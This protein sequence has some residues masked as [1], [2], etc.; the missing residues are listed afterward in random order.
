MR[1][2]SFWRW[3]LTF[4]VKSTAIVHGEPL[5]SYVVGDTVAGTFDS[6][7]DRRIG[8]FGR[9]E[10]AVDRVSLLDP[11]ASAVAGNRVRVGGEDY[12]IVG[13]DDTETVW[14][15]ALKRVVHGA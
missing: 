9:L 3:R 12:D 2:A 8:R 10:S 7:S 15:L 1:N 11:H 13:V 6:A 14:A 5:D 4:L